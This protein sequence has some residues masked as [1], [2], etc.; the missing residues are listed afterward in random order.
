VEWSDPSGL[1]RKLNPN[2]EECQSLAKSISNKKIDINKRIQDLNRNNKKLPYN[3]LSCFSKPRD[4]IRGHEELI[5]DLKDK[6]ADDEDLYLAKCGGTDDGESS[7]LNNAK[8]VSGFV[9]TASTLYW[10]ISAGSRVVFP[11]RNLIPIP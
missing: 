7:L 6:L 10:L 8:D 3:P 2:S 11:P 9:A 4:S 1:V 5:E